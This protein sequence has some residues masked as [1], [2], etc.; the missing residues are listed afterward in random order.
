[1]GQEIHTVDGS[2]IE[3][4]HDFLYLASCT[5]SFADISKVSGNEFFLNFVFTEMLHQDILKIVTI[6]GA[7]EGGL[8]RQVEFFEEDI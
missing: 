7:S 4:D 6:C 3:I 1:M 5:D 8:R 2:T